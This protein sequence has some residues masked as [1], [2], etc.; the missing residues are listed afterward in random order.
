MD[1][2]LATY[3]MDGEPVK[4]GIWVSWYPN[5]QKKH[6]GTYKNDVPM[7]EFTWWHENGQRSLVASYKD[8]KKQGKWTWWHPNGLKSI[9]GEYADNTPSS[10]W[11][12]WAE[13]GKVAQRA[14]FNDPNQRHI[15]AMPT[16]NNDAAPAIPR[17]SALPIPQLLR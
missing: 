5:G 8:G 10:K 1:C 15:L 7:G 13:T 9:Q 2:T 3:S 16:N 6:E 4:Q 17:A 14:D 11:L 12:W